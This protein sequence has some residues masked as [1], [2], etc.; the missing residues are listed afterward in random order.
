MLAVFACAHPVLAAPEK[1]TANFQ[2]QAYLAV[3]TAVS[4]PAATSTVELLFRMIIVIGVL[5]AVGW[6]AA[7]FLRRSMASTAIG[8]WVA[9]IDQ[10]SLGPNR[11]LYVT[12]LA[13]R[14]FVLAITEHAVQP[15]MEIT[16]PAI[17]EAMRQSRDNQKNAL[18][19][20]EGTL[21]W[22][23]WL[24][25]LQRLTKPA[26]DDSFQEK[27]NHQLALLQQTKMSNEDKSPQK[28]EQP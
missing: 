24:T 27:I 13:G 18:L 6:G 23:K 19:S 26:T 15:I 11:S 28:G 25:H 7:R 1:E 20:T 22:Q 17:I 8:D 16:D 2:D 3:D 5:G 4:P 21:P 10:A 14:F 9:V 12:E